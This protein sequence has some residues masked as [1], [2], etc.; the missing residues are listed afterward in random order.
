VNFQFRDAGSV[1][2]KVPVRTYDDVRPDKFLGEP[3]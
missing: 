1:T 3:F 2:L